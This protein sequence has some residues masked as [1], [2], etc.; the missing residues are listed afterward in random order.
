MNFTT[1]PVF[2]FYYLRG[3]FNQAAVIAAVVLVQEPIAQLP[4]PRTKES[5]NEKNEQFPENGYQRR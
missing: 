5:I 1:R 4:I 3:A 2:I